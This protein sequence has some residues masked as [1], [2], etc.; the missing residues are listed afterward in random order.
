MDITYL[1]HSSFK[2]KTKNA[3]IIT[4]PF[5]P[6]MIG[7]KFP[8]VEADIVTISHQHGDHNHL[9]QILGKV[10]DQ[11]TNQPFVIEGPGEYEVRGINILGISTFHDNS[12]GTERGKNTIYEFRVE[13]L[14]LIHCGDLGHKLTDAQKESLGQPDILF[15]P[16][17]GKYTIDPAVAGEVINQL[18]PKI[19]VPMH[20]QVGGLAP[21]LVS[22]LVPVTEFL[23]V[24]GKG[25][26]VPQD[27]LTITRDKLPEEIQIVVLK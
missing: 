19:I 5:D 12:L 11:G 26:M 17:G 22:E 14:N 8:K 4:D 24:M 13:G 9:A 16:T 23:K 15:I 10:T 2:I 1:G 18:E 25:E 3:T 7:L 21:K 27:K 6:E 20:Y